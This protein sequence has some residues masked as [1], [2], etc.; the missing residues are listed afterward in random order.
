MKT[1]KLTV[2][3]AGHVGS[4]V[5]AYA[6]KSDLFGEIAVIDPRDKIAFGEALDQ[7]HATGLLSRRNID[8]HSGGYE[9]VADADIIIV[10]ATHVYAPDPVPADRQELIKTNAAIVRE[11]MTNVV[12][13]TRDA[14]IIFITNPADTVTYIA[15]NEFDYPTNQILST[16]CTLDSARLRHFI[17]RHYGVDPK[18]VD[19]Y[20]MG[21]HGYTAFPVLSRLTVGGIAFDEL[22]EYFPDVVP[23]TPDQIT[24]HVV[25]TAYE[26]FN[27][28]VGVTNAGV[29]ESSLE[30]ARAILLDEKSIYPVSV[31][32]VNGE[33]GFDQPSAFSVPCILGRNGIERR[34][35][36]SLNEWETDKL[37]I[38]VASIQASIELAESLK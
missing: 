30:L 26:V 3:G 37:K 23:L 18:S 34:L 1:Q 10:A 24:E 6:A 11:I 9:E 27:A 22:T 17:G 29:A 12:K 19:G 32:F 38:S 16:G 25:Q 4:H 7:D 15:T 28:K 33:Y 36:V 20:M 13:Y 5:L 14:I 2:I 8:I 31:P 21:E 35:T